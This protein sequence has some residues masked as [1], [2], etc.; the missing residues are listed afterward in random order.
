MWVSG[1][2]RGVFGLW[3]ERRGFGEVGANW[4]WRGGGCHINVKRKRE[5][6]CWKWFHKFFPEQPNPLPIG[7]EILIFHNI[8]LAQIMHQINQ[9]FVLGSTEYFG[10]LNKLEIRVPTTSFF[11]L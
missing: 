4:G 9:N 2:F 7:Q 8:S 3:G 5:G 1:F 11:N 6:G 10:I